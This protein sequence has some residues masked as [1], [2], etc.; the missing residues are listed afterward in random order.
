[1]CG[2]GNEL[3]IHYCQELGFDVIGSEREWDLG[4]KLREKQRR[5]DVV[6]KNEKRRAE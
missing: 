3:Y 4:V 1:M 5:V 6:I 2:H